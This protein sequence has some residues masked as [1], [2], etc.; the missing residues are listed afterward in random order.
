MNRRQML[1]RIAKQARKD[2]VEFGFEREGGSHSVYRLGAKTIPVPRHNDIDDDLA[3]LI[4]KQTEAYL[5]KG[6]WRR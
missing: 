2:G 1:R 4:F 6:W 3:R 5:T